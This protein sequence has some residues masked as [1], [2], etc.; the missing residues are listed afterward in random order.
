M[1]TNNVAFDGAQAL[2]L[3]QLPHPTS[4]QRRTCEVLLCKGD[5]DDYAFNVMSVAMLAAI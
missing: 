3:T 2:P 1:S 5:G 4:T